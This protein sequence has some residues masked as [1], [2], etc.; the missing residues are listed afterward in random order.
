MGGMSFTTITVTGTFED[1]GGI[2]LD[3]SV[4][5]QL[6]IPMQNGNRIVQ[7]TPVKRPVTKGK[8][9]F[10]LLASDDPETLPHNVFYE[11]TVNVKTPPYSFRA[12]V[13]HA[14][15]EHTIDIATLFENSGFVGKIPTQRPQI[16]ASQATAAEVASILGLLG[17]VELTQ[18]KT[19]RFE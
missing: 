17:L 11:F 1:A 9:S 18:P 19:E 16:V 7:P 3:G 2:P 5:A 8:C 14:A 13:P 10:A 15:P 6:L 4:T 12:V